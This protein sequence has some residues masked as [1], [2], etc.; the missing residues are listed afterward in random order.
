MMADCAEAF[1]FY[2]FRGVTSVFYMACYRALLA[3]TGGLVYHKCSGHETVRSKSVKRKERCN[4]L[5]EN[6][7]AIRK[8]KGLSQEEL[9]GRVHVVRQTVSKWEQGISVPDADLLVALSEALETPVSVL[10]GEPVAEA[11]PTDIRTLADK[12]EAVN[13]QLAQQLTQKKETRRKWLHGLFWAVCILTA[14][15]FALLAALKSPYLGWDQSDPE[16]AVF[17]AAYHVFEF[18]F[19]R[20]APFLL[21]GA[22]A[23]VFFTRKKR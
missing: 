8:E 19:V 20:L 16:T 2:A 7:K 15:L 3:A 10:L 21:I 5:H 18:L 4:M 6:L 14:A 23:G 22:A 9:A 17:G 1:V 13:L 12:L 11:R